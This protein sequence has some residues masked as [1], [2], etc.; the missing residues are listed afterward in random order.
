MLRIMG[1]TSRHLV[2][3]SSVRSVK[4]D[5]SSLRPFHESPTG[6][7][8]YF[9][10]AHTVYQQ[11]VNFIDFESFIIVFCTDSMTFQVIHIRPDTLWRLVKNVLQVSALSCGFLRQ[12]T[13]LHIV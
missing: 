9:V 11:K 7:E 5:G 8:N 3:A 1:S 10:V 13:L 2:I 4:A 12:Q 6:I